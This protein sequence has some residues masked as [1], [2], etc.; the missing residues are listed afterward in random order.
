MICETLRRRVI[1][2]YV[3][4]HLSFA[5]IFATQERPDLVVLPTLD[6]DSLKI[7][8]DTVGDLRGFDE[9]DSLGE[10]DE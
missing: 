6:G 2:V 8:L 1:A 9:E 5:P 3:N 7:V 10:S 4:A